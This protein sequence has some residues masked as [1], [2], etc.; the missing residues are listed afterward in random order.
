MANVDAV[1]PT[2]SGDPT[3]TDGQ[4]EVQAAFQTG[5]LNFML[6]VLQSSESDVI[7]A[8]NDDTSDPDAVG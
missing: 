4:A 8:I 2:N 3:D 5:L 7:D 1:A 6:S